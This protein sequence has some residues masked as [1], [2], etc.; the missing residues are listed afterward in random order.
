MHKKSITYVDFDGVERTEDF[1]FNI[2][3]SEFIDWEMSIPGGLKNKI[4]SISKSKDRVAMF[5]FF[6]EF[7]MKAYGEKSDDGKH[8]E[9]SEEISKSFENTNAYDVLILEL[10]SSEDAASKFFNAVI[11]PISEEQRVEAEKQL[12]AE[13]NA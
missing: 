8:F 5:K 13:L 7:I 9:K 3:Q 11:P 1:Y 6:K 10:F 12:K 4:I 2:N